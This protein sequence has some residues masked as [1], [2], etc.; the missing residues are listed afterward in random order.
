[1]EKE[2][3]TIYIGCDVSKGYADFCILKKNKELVV[4]NFQLDDTAIGHSKL[5]A[6]IKDI[7]NKTPEIEI[8]SAVESTGGYEN[9]WYNTLKQLSE[10]HNLKVTR[11]NPW[12]VNLNQKAGLKRNITDAIS[13]FNIAEYIIDH[14]DKVQYQQDDTFTSLRCYWNLIKMNKKHRKEL[15]NE[16]EIALYNAN[17]TLMQYRKGKF[18]NWLSELLILYPTATDLANANIEELIKIPNITTSKAEKL[19]AEAKQSVASRTDA[20]TKRHI[21]ETVTQIKTLDITIKND[22]DLVEQELTNIKEYEE[23]L[24]V[25]KSFKGI[26]TI[27]AIGILLEIGSIKRFKNVKAICCY[28]GVQPKFKQSGDRTSGV[29]MSKQ[30]S[31]IMREILFNIAKGA[32]VY[33]PVIKATYEKKVSEGMSKMAAIGVCMHKTLRIIYGMLKH[34]QNFDPNIDKLNAERSNKK[35]QDKN[36][37]SLVNAIKSRRFQTFDPSAPISNKQNKKRKELNSS[38]SASK[39][40]NTGSK[41]SFPVSS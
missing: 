11:L 41:N 19:I 13:A 14:S 15:L 5:K 8:Y 17:P 40:H 9:N 30:G 29:H 27:S 39:A 36:N 23:V 33:N 37:Q 35:C 3:K 22:I 26:N 28:F 1:M 31:K 10:S 38:Q 6:L 16:L 34:M 24:T 4:K 25:L 32:I 12:G 7:F 21:I 18:P 20:F 2:K